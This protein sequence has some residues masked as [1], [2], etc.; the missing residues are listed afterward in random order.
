[1]MGKCAGTTPMCRDA[2]ELTVW[3]QH[4]K[5]LRLCGGTLACNA[6]PPAR[7]RPRPGQRGVVGHEDRRCLVQQRLQIRRSELHCGA[8]FASR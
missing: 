1:M 6:A 3:P 8:Q 7:P 4:R 5:P 2:S